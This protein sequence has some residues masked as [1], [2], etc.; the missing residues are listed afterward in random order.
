MK[1]Y[2][3]EIANFVGTLSAARS[4]PIISA[5]GNFKAISIALQ[6]DN[7]KSYC[8]KLDLQDP[9]KHRSPNQGLVLR[10]APHFCPR[11]L[12]LQRYLLLWGTDRRATEATF[13]AGEKAA[14]KKIVKI[15]DADFKDRILHTSIS[16]E[17]AGN[18]YT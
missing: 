10:T 11:A 2:G 17:S 13:Y 1:V 7:I 5:C 8:G 4:I 18:L 6:Y 3:E 12:L 9:T 14:I 16:S 15:V